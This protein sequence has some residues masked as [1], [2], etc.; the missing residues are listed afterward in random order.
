VAQNRWHIFTHGG[1]NDTGIDAIEWAKEAYN[2][3]AGELLVTSMDSD[4]TKNG[5]AKRF[6]FTDW[7]GGEYSD[8]CEWRSWNYGTYSRCLFNRKI[9]RSVG[10]S[11]FH[12]REIDIMD[13]NILFKNRKIFL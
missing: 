10:G 6:K 4:G 11:I 1:R 8:N 5:F 9:G 2:R 12:F 3:G 7:G 13:F